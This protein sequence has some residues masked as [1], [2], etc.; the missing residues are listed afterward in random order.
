[1]NR[2]RHIMGFF[3]SIFK[4]YGKDGIQPFVI[5]FLSRTG[6]NFLASKLDSH[7]DILCHHE[8]FNWNCPHRS[9]SAKE[10]TIILDLG[11]A[12]DR[13]YNPWQFISMVY[14]TP[15]RLPDGRLNRVKS[16]GFKMS[17]AQGLLVVLS[18]MLN[19]SVKKVVLHRENLLKAY[20][21]RL[22][23][24]K[25]K[26]YIDLK[27]RSDNKFSEKDD[28]KVY[29]NPSE[30]IK[31][32]RNRTLFHR[33]TLLLLKLSF[34]KAFEIEFKEITDNSK[35]RDLIRFLGVSKDFADLHAQ[36]QRQAWR[37]L[38]ERIENIEELRLL[39]KNSRH[40]DYLEES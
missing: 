20:V 23:A 31:Y 26:T 24:M 8:V 3:P 30:Y 2:L 4:R 28:S 39:F 35:I 33:S 17:P 38:A 18:L 29:V 37:T 15:G 11:K 10:G 6:S 1:M 32:A 14:G 21:S 19:R 5:I 40:G 7:P 16:I 12:K 13:D 9:L 27:K 22:F 25:T 36:T 34:Q